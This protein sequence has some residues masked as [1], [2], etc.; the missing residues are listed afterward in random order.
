MSG[1]DKTTFQDGEHGVDRCAA[2]SVCSCPMTRREITDRY[3]LDARS[4]LLDIA[5]FLD[6]L[7]RARDR[8][9][10]AADFR[11]D[12]LRDASSELLSTQPGR[13]KRI[14]SLWSDPTVEPIVELS[15]KGATGAWPGRPSGQS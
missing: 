9:D 6:R 4:K 11:V 15:G 5:A 2:D 13:T 7:D 12:A 8:N 1:N 14:Q 10:S 3:F